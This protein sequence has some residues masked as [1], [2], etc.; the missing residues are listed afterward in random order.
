ML[1]IRFMVSFGLVKVSLGLV[2]L[3]GYFRV[4]LK[5]EFF[6]VIYAAALR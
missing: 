3:L 2:R 4:R 1:R 5:S 6:K